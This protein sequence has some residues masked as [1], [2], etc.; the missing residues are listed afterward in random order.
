MFNILDFNRDGRVDS[1]ELLRGM[2]ETELISELDLE[3][4]LILADDYGNFDREE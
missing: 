2:M 4:R 1:F 3:S